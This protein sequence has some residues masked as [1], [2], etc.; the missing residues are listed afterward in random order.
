MHSIKRVVVVSVVVSSFATKCQSFNIET[1][2]LITNNRRID[3][4]LYLFGSLLKPNIKRINCK[5]RGRGSTINR[6]PKDELDFMS[7][8]YGLLDGDIDDPIPPPFPYTI[9]LDPPTTLIS[10]NFN[11]QP[12]RLIIRHLEDNE[13]T[14]ILPEI[15]REFGALVSSISPP[16]QPSN[17]PSGVS[18]FADKIHK[19]QDEL[20]DK[21]ENYLFSLTVLIGLTQ[22][23][24]RREKGYDIS[25][26]ACP[27]HNVVCL[28]EQIADNIGGEIMYKEQIIGIAELSWQP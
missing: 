7:S 25:N 15:V 3:S 6:I 28:V 14:K 26:S 22:R 16:P 8:G 23:V 21:L 19:Q 17:E 20:A 10:D 27:D 12:D 13:I 24:V 2:S 18:E 9:E 4:T 1:H 5:Q 11:N